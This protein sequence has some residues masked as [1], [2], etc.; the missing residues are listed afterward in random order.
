MQRP[1]TAPDPA[2]GLGRR[3]PQS[4]AA[5]GRATQNPQLVATLARLEARLR[6][7][8]R[9]RE[10]LQEM[11]YES[12]ATLGRAGI[13]YEPGNIRERISAYRVFSALPGRPG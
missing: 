11:L 12:D 4:L 9:E 10:A 13:R 6:A 7:L 2:A 8:L 1:E 5:S 3:D